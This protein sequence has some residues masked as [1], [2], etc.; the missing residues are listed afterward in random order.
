MPGA[1][2]EHARK[3]LR[4]RGFSASTVLPWATV[5]GGSL[6]RY[7]DYTLVYF[8]TI[9][10]STAA[11]TSF[12]NRFGAAAQEGRGVHM[13]DQTNDRQPISKPAMP[14][15]DVSRLVAAQ[16]QVSRDVAE[17]AVIVNLENG[18]YY[19]TNP[20]GT[21]IWQLIIRQESRTFAD[22]R[23]TLLDE[24]DVDAARLEADLR[25]FVEQLFVHGLV[26]LTE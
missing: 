9:G 21:R 24:F 19:S 7:D 11:A 22:L 14:L 5:A 20:V 6:R 26:E 16:H 12:T 1:S 25:V 3:Q 15:T 4:N 17:E 18:V 23:N 13:T 8:A 10:G 2:L